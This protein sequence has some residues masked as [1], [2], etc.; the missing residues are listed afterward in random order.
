MTIALGDPAP[1]GLPQ[2]AAFG[3]LISNIRCGEKKFVVDV[4]M[5]DSGVYASSTERKR[6]KGQGTYLRRS[7]LLILLQNLFEAICP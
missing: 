5:E 6:E 2:L 3:S 7:K 1:A 4:T